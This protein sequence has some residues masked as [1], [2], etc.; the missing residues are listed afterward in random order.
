MTEGLKAQHSTLSELLC[1]G[2]EMAMPPYQRSYS[3]DVEEA[4]ALLSDLLEIADSS[5]LHFIGAIV[6]VQESSGRYLIVD[7][8]QRLTTLT[9]L[10]SV[11]RDFAQDEA[12]AGE[13]QKLIVDAPDTDSKQAPR[14]RISLNH[15]DGPY[16][17]SAVQVSGSTR[18]DLIEPNDGDS[19]SRMARNLDMYRRVIREL[20]PE[21]RR[22]LANAALNRLLLV[23]VVVEDWDGGYNVFRVLNTRGKAPNSHDI[24]KTDL[25]ENAGLTGP[26]ANNFAR[27]WS[28]HEARLGGSGFDD[29]LNQIRMLYGRRNKKGATEFR[30]T[31][32]GRQSGDV[33]TFLERDLPAFVDAYVA[34]SR[35]QLEFGSL[36]SAISVP[37]NHLRLLDH[38]LWRGSA[39][40]FLVNFDGPPETAL[41]VFKNLERLAYACMLVITEPRPRQKRYQRV[42]EA[43]S[44]PA[45]LLA[46]NSPLALSRDERRRITERL[47]SRFGAFAQRRAIALRLNAE[48]QGGRALGPSDG[49]TVE[50]VL[51]RMI[52]ED[53]P[54]NTAWP[55]SAVHRELVNTIGNF[56]LLSQQANQKAD[57]LGFEDKKDLYFVD[58]EPE[59]ALTQD[60]RDHIT[61][62]PDTVRTRTGHLSEILVQAWQLD[63]PLM[64]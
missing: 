43:A 35:G 29:L 44:N 63:K 25:L 40:K 20:P 61:W 42:A 15:L 16:F 4:E 37:L 27:Q 23:K 64:D 41:R 7:G 59:F 38:H 51:P 34:I 33:R 14:W 56:A 26:D 11:L 19:Q 55:N 57:N 21:S 60:I 58:G 54:W 39:L 49:A 12:H 17:R 47:S 18:S 28:E 31:V 3:W 5:D 1:A 30:R 13:L 50:H 45:S 46:S 32:I 6:L 9:I 22:K 62:T 24:I 53:S 52:G 10:L 48:I 8:Q 36:S 2:V